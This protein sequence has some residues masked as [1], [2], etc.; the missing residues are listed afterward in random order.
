M[1][2]KAL[3]FPQI[4]VV[5]GEDGTGMIT[6]SGQQTIV[7]QVNLALARTWVVKYL[8]ATARPL[9]R[10]VKATISDPDGAFAIIVDAEGTVLDATGGEAQAVAPAGATGT[11]PPEQTPPLTISHNG[12]VIAHLERSLIL[13]RRPTN[14]ADTEI[15]TIGDPT[16]QVSKT[17]LRLD[18]LPDGYWATDLGS[19][20]GTAVTL[21][22][23]Q[24]VQLETETPL[25]ITQGA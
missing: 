8:A 22:G 23:R 4:T 14:T 24:R 5:L 9:R 11:I 20:N 25:R 1:N 19:T 17:H 16:R 15:L 7:H 3:A 12:L 2:E 21:E 6:M 10:P 18:H 13:G